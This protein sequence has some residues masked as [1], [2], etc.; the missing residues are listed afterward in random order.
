M[1]DEK[2]FIADYYFFVFETIAV[3][4]CF[5]QDNLFYL[6]N[7]GYLGISISLGVFCL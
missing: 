5:T 2:I 4:L 7:F 1:Q 3:T 6:F